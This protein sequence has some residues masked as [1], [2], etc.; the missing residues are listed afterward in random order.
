MSPHNP[1]TGP[2]LGCVLL[3]CV[4]FACSDPT[5]AEQLPRPTDDTWVLRVDGGDLVAVWVSPAVRDPHGTWF[6]FV[7]A[8]VHQGAPQTSAGATSVPVLLDSRQSVHLVD[9]GMG[10]EVVPEPGLRWADVAEQQHLAI[11]KHSPSLPSRPLPDEPAS[12]N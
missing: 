1:K 8:T 9:A 3:L 4:C 10:V 12:G 2:L 7:N 11:R 6:R 5:A